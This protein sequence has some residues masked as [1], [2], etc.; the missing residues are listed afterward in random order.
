M[1]KGIYDC[2]KHWYH[3]GS[4]WFY[5]D[6]HFADEEMTALRKNYI[7]DEEQVRSINSKIGKN[8]TLIILGD[9]GNPEFLKQIRGYKVLILGNHDKGASVY[10]PYVNEVYEGALTISDKIILTHEPVDVP[11]MFN[12]HGHDHSNWHGKD[13]MHFNMCAEAINYTPVS[14]SQMIKSGTF[15]DVPNIHRLVIDK[16]I[17]KKNG[18]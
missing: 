3:G 6:P 17:R 11:F 10:A 13:K 1:I 2:F 9:I 7:G 15:K 18:N 16:A 5:S 12:I 4:I 8:D 14:F